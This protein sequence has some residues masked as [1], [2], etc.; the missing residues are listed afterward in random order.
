[1]FL[2]D[3]LLGAPAKGLF[4]IFKAIHDR[5][6]EEMYNPDKIRE[7]LLLIQERLENGKIDEDEYDAQ[8]EEL[9]NRL[10]EALARRQQ[11]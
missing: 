8:E 6:D 1:M 2:I 10:D 9:L 7:Q 4:N 5:V 3:D 11:G